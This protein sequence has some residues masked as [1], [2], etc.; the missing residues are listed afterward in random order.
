MVLRQ[1]HSILTSP[2]S[3]LVLPF[4][5]T[6]GD[7][8]CALRRCGL[9][10]LDALEGISILSDGVAQLR[11]E[12]ER[13][14]CDNSRFLALQAESIASLRAHVPGLREELALLTASLHCK[15]PL[16]ESLSVKASTSAGE[17]PINYFDALHREML[18]VY[19]P[20]LLSSVPVPVLWR[21]PPL[22]RRSNEAQP[23]VAHLAH[24]PSTSLNLRSA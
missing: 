16:A 10:V 3:R 8:D 1:L 2:T 22:Y 24:L 20:T 19:S 18:S 17:P 15:S 7:L 23:P 5:P 9:Y 4:Q 12:N 13:P 21:T 6:T 11:E 14:R